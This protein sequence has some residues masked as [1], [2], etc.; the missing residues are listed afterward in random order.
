MKTVMKAGMCEFVDY[1]PIVSNDTTNILPLHWLNDNLEDRADKGS[2]GIPIDSNVVTSASLS[3]DVTL[4]SRE[5]KE[6]IKMPAY[7]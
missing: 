7:H 4:M 5:E 2:T 6:A 1:F 3:S